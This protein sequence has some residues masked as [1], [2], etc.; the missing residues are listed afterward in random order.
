MFPF[1]RLLSQVCPCFI[2]SSTSS[3]WAFWIWRKE[4]RELFPSLTW[5][6]LSIESSSRL[7]KWGLS[8]RLRSMNPQAARRKQRCVWRALR[9]T[10]TTL[11]FH[12]LSLVCDNK[13]FVKFISTF[14][15]V[16]LEP[17][18]REEPSELWRSLMM[19]LRLS[20]SHLKFDI[21]LLKNKLMFQ[22]SKFFCNI[23]LKALKMFKDWRRKW[24]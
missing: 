17:M 6:W 2:L 10:L 21:L 23:Y 12:L 9:S 5:H 11:S 20:F 16:Y 22:A 3:N 24:L 8:T 1:E 4:V 18:M 19:G 7:G 13:I 14:A 15:A